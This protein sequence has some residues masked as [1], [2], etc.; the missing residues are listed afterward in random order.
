MQYPHYILSDVLQNELQPQLSKSPVDVRFIYQTG[1]KETCEILHALD[2][3]RPK[4]N[5][6]F[7]IGVVWQQ[8]NCNADKTLDDYVCYLSKTKSSFSLQAS[9]HHSQNCSISLIC[10]LRI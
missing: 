3:S 8:C 7:S 1:H 10:G 6:G 5:N 4:N 2:F 9:I